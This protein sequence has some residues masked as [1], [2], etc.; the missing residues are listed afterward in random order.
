MSCCASGLAAAA[1][2]P[3][4]ALPADPR[5][6]ELR[7]SARRAEDGTLTYVLSVPNISCGA[8]IG[9]VESALKPLPGV[10]DARVNLTLR[11]V[12]ITAEADASP[13]V[14]VDTLARRGYP[15]TPI[16]LGDLSDLGRSRE[17]NRL[18]VALA[19]AGFAAANIMLLSVSVW[20]GA[21][22]ATRDVFHLVSALIA[23][24]TVAISGQV[25]FRSAFGALRA[26]RLNMDVPISLAL[27]LALGMSLYESL[28]GGA[29]AYF[30]AAV[31]LLFFLLIG[32]FLDQRMRERARSAVA[33]IARLAAKGATRIVD[34]RPVYVPIDE[35]RP[36]MLLRVNAGERMPVDA[37]IA[38]GASEVDRSLVTGESEP[39]AVT[40]G[41]RA[42]AGTLN[43]SGSLDV[44]ALTGAE[45][46]YLAEI[47]RMMEAAE[48]GRG[49][50]VRIADRMARLYAPVVHVLAA[51]TFLGWLVLT[52]GDWYHAAYAAIAVL[53][54][55]CPCALGL[56]VP[57]VHVIGA[58]RLFEAGILMKDG[59]AIERLAEVDSV[60]FDKTGTL[61]TGMPAVAWSD[62]RQGHERAIVRALAARSNHPASRAVLAW[63]GEGPAADLERV[64]E[65][66]GS[67]IEAQVGGR[68]VRLGRPVWV[69][70]IA[71]TD[72]AAPVGGTAF[73]IEGGRT[74]GFR[75]RETLREGAREAVDELR[76]AGM[77]LELLSGDAEGP[78]RALAR[79][80]GLSHAGFAQ[81]PASKIARIRELQ[82]DGACVLMVGDGLNDAPSLSAGDVSM[83]PASACDA[84]RLAADFVFTRDSLDAVP[85]AWRVARKA[86][87]LVRQNFAMAIAYN[88]VAVPLAVTG[89]VTPLVA[90]IAMS[91]SSILVVA[92]SLRLARR[93]AIPTT[94]GRSLAATA[95]IEP[96][97]PAVAA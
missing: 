20:S 35:V 22:A 61:T 32:R 1:A 30:D 63:L 25:F 62:L 84:G 3:E 8:C 13:L 9:A 88:A 53:I 59:S 50:Y 66:P 12:T 33:G 52:G 26:G 95:P 29:E 86:K 23:V 21:D 64:R 43:L 45:D 54:I 47:M 14:F 78:V 81:T 7:R 67:G 15:A 48:S 94:A 2:A 10:I 70:E 27:V 65:V 93:G 83:A 44:E 51:A 72:D 73:A 36:G 17:S 85:F 77:A 5:V 40:P 69:A 97:A 4:M 42:E 74:A 91:S 68:S 58:G 49:A 19:I 79:D 24:P 38:S 82:K 96:E 90:A 28:T 37:R 46:S 87:A 71:S 76:D 89:L 34:G 80:L 18:L 56:A 11:R 31:T 16:D 55:T 39:V 92:N 60:V 57:V 75:L 41:S 6:E